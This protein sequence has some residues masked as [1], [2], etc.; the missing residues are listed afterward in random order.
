MPMM[1]GPNELAYLTDLIL[2]LVAGIIIGGERELK[3]KPAGIS[4][5]TLVIGAAMTFTFLSQT[6]GVGDPTRIAAQIVSGVGFLGAG[7]IL[8]SESSKRVS[9]LTT[10]ASIWYA[11]AIGMALGFNFH[12]IAIVATLYAVIVSRLPHIGHRDLDDVSDEKKK[13]KK[14]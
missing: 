4:T 8:R 3:R 13:S 14:L 6:V 10:A 2:A 7:V 11:A 1:L 5:Q 9:N 12:L